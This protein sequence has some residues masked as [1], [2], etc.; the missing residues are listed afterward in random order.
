MNQMETSIQ[1][2]IQAFEKYRE[3]D[4]K[5]ALKNLNSIKSGKKNNDK[6]SNRIQHNILI[7]EFSLAESKGQR[8]KVIEQL[9]KLI[10]EIDGKGVEEENKNQKMKKKDRNEQEI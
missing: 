7:C 2:S 6:T 8:E 3:S 9:E 1:I 5:E 4:Y 10:Y